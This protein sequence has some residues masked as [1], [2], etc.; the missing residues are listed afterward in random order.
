VVRA[1]ALGCGEWQ[2][3]RAPLPLPPTPLSLTSCRGSL[4]LPLVHRGPAQAAE[5]PGQQQG[6][7][8]AR[9]ED[10]A[11][12]FHGRGALQVRCTHGTLLVPGTHVGARAGDGALLGVPAV[13]CYHF[14]LL[15]APA[16][17]M[18]PT[19]GF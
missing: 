2:R 13:P 6:P 4:G 9:E 17:C 5:G 10:E 18:T 15:M 7:W 1:V 8:V 16:Y 19:S 12:R 14:G 3:Q 11:F